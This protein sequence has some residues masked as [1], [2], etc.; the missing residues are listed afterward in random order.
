MPVRTLMSNSRGWNSVAF[1]SNGTLLASG[2]GDKVYLWRTDGV[3][4]HILEGHE[5]LVQ[6]VPSVAFSADGKLFAS[7]GYEQIYVWGVPLP[8]T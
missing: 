8:Y 6:E 3:L 4:M 5:G 1:S 2:A 7:G